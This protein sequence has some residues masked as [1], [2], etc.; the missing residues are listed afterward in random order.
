MIASERLNA[1]EELVPEWLATTWISF[2][3]LE[4]HTPYKK[5]VAEAARKARRDG[6]TFTTY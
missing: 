1:H 6:L 3:G 2:D 4:D 5:K